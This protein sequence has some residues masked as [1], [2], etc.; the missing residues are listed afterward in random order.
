[1]P[2]FKINRKPS[3]HFAKSCQRRQLATASAT[4][5]IAA[6]MLKKMSNFARTGMSTQDLDD[7]D[8]DLMKEVGATSACFGYLRLKCKYPAYSG[9]SLNNELVQGIPSNDIIFKD[10]DVVSINLSL[11][12]DGFVGDNTRIVRISEVSSEAENLSKT[13]KKA[14]IVGIAK[15]I[16]GNRIEDIFHAFETHVREHNYGV[17]KEFVG[18]DAGKDVHEEPKILNYGRAYTCPI[19]K[20]GMTLA[21]ELMFAQGNPAVY[22]RNDGRTVKTRDGSLAA[23][24]EH[25]ILVTNSSPEIST[26]VKK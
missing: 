13:T 15:A 4:S 5:R 20:A 7:F 12:Y 3:F 25:T 8:R 1:V 14:R 23:H 9:I 19:L 10:G 16:A 18:H 26:L 2:L 17:V 11:F 21:I 22:V 6:E 24:C